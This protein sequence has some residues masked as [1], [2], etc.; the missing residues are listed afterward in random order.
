MRVGLSFQ[1]DGERSAAEAWAPVLAEMG[2]ADALGYDSVWAC[3]ERDGPETCASPTIFLTFAA[4]RTKSVQL[5][6]AARSVTRANPVRLAEEVAVLDHFSRGRAGLAFAAAGRQGV[7]TGRVHEAL[8][9]VGAAW[10]ADEFR[11]RGDFFRFPAHTE[12]DAPPGASEPAEAGEYT[13]QWE[14]GPIMPDFLAITPKPYATRPPLYVEIEDDETL[15]WAARHAISPVVRADVPTQKAVE[16]LARYREAADAAGRTRGEVDAVLE[17]RIA[18]DGEADSHTLG[19]SAR[20]LV[21][22]IRDVRISSLI[23]HLVWQRSA[24]GGADLFRFAAEVQP[25]LQS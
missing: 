17:R 5:R 9:L 13:P 3:E 23:S 16:R 12:D 19:G 14:W 21:N 1:L 10:A 20:D 6:S 2:Q 22:A 7:P 24:N 8:D 15:E 25:L 11:Y 4:R 18:L